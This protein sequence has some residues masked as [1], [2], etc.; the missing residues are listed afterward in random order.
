MYDNGKITRGKIREKADTIMVTDSYVE[1]CI[2][3]AL[4]NNGFELDINV[5]SKPN[6]P[7][8]K[9]ITIYRVME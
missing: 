5:I 6:E 4:A 2:I 3:D 8:R 7:Y 1:R 9:E